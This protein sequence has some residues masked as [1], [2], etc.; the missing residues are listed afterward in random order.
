VGKKER[1]GG[2]PDPALRR[3][4]TTYAKGKRRGKTGHAFG[5]SSKLLGVLLL[6]LHHLLK[7]KGGR[8]RKKGVQGRLAE[9]AGPSSPA[10]RCKNE[11]RGERKRGLNEQLLGLCGG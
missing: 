11:R 7:K 8:K 9:V 5:R 1:R 4:V 10:R 6:R 3:R 2:T